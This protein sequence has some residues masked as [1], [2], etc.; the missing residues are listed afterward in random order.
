M[1]ANARQVDSRQPRKAR[2][3]TPESRLLTRGPLDGRTREGMFLSS[4]ERGLHDH[5]GRPATFPETLLIKRTARLLLRLELIDRKDSLTD[6]DLRM[7]ASWE[8]RARLCLAS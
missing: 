8:N 5:L 3:L 1:E 6:H 2:R 4:V 7:A